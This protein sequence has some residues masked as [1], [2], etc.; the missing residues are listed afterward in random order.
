MPRDGHCKQPALCCARHPPGNVTAQPFCAGRCAHTSSR[1]LQH[2]TRHQRAAVH[3]ELA[4]GARE[5]A[6]KFAD[7]P[8]VQRVE[9]AL[10][11]LEATAAATGPARGSG[12]S[13]GK[14]VVTLVGAG[15]AGVCAAPAL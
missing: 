2:V 7:F 14:P 3:A 8:D 15:Y 10:S 11:A 13:G 12:T 5:H 6:L 1:Q 9:A 4:E